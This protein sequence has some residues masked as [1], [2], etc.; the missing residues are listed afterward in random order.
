MLAKRLWA[1]FQDD[2]D[3]AERPEAAWPEEAEPEAVRTEAV[4]LHQSLLLSALS[5][6]LRFIN[7]TLKSVFL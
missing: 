4:G 7:I 3:D 1:L 2:N 6:C 5:E